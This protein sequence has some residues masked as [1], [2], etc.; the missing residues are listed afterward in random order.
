MSPFQR[1]GGA[2]SLLAAVC[3]FVFGAGSA[4][5]QDSWNP[6]ADSPQPGQ[7]RSARPP[8]PPME[9]PFDRREQPPGPGAA[10][11]MPGG[12]APRASVES[13][14]LPPLPA[15]GAAVAGVAPP[16]GA[17]SAPS[18]ADSAALAKLVAEIE[19]PARS[20][21]VTR[22]L[23]RVIGPGATLA[24]APE[25]FSARAIALYRAGRLSE[26]GQIGA[27]AGGL[28]RDGAAGAALAGIRARLAL[29][30]GNREQSCTE[31]L[32]LVQAGSSP[33][34]MAEGIALKGY[35]SAVSGNPGAASLA[36]SLGR[37]QGVPAHVIAALEAVAAGEPHRLGG[38][39]RIGV[40]EWRLAELAGKFEGPMP[41]ANRLELATTVAIALSEAA[42]PRWRLVAG[43]TSARVNAVDAGALGEIYRAQ[44]F[45]PAELDL[46]VSGRGD[47]VSRRA[48][49]YRA[50]EAERAPAKRARIIRAALDDAR[51][52]G[53]Y[54][55]TA[56][57]FAPL[58]GE[59]V[60]S[61]EIG[62]FA[63]T[64]VEVMLAAGR[65]EEARRWT[66]TAQA[67]GS[68]NLAH[69]NALIDLADAPSRRGRGASLAFVEEIALS[70]RFT[71]EG[72]HRLAT[73]LDALDYDVPMRL[74]EAASRAPQPN[75]GF[76]PHTGLLSELQDAAK[77]K[78]HLRTATLVHR[79]L[80]IDG[81][82][83]AHM[84]ALGDSIRALK[85]A[86]LEVDAR[87][88]A[89]EALFVLW[90]RSSSS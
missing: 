41:P 32:S 64:G 71:A 40:L 50:A 61:P 53:L 19:L 79:A 39:H 44:Q 49:L 24:S 10:D 21:A 1:L 2:S 75:T 7:R 22:L 3:C 36:A 11:V 13:T 69:W 9:G 70:G 25:V 52:A 89:L 20:A 43:E 90:P 30:A 87:A 68:G 34:L 27:D 58:A 15:D 38:T 66:Q 12:F 8:L 18:T 28:P 82:E 46:A 6:F 80:G 26:A 63:E 57:A 17:P 55:V 81:P 62:W 16:S 65:L 73:V 88:V 5:A 77:R 37:E 60:P 33:A 76:L 59:V 48:A 54:T 47:S 83:G 74:W 31:S 72:L 78:D 23:V 56:A 51:R 35:C 42:P 86:G 29:A 67:G 84:I 4:G 45:S 14:E 85:R